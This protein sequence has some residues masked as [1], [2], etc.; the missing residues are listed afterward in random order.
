VTAGQF[1][2]LLG[3]A[4]VVIVTPGQDTA[5]TIRNTIRGGRPGGLCTA[6]GVSAGQAT[7]TIAAA[8][9][10][11]AALLASESAFVLLKVVGSLYLVA[12]GVQ[13]L[14][15][16]RHTRC[17]TM[18][19]GSGSV[20]ADV[21]PPVALRQ[22]LVSNL[23]NPKMLAFFS[24][25]LPQFASSF[26]GLLALGLLFSIL[27]LAWLT[28]YTIAISKLNRFLSP[29][30]ARSVEAATGLVLIG[31]GLALVTQA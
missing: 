6:I 8:A 28:V 4:I 16:A 24:S 30:V 17:V 11:A 31:F 15:L 26:A 3:I 9:G 22:E 27:T 19:N 25:L 1:L 12:L 20:D 7:W 13:S 23:S 14:V 10:M 5:L 18:A 29:V 2:A 21:R